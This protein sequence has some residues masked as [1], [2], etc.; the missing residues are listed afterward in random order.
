MYHNIQYQAR[1]SG[2]IRYFKSQMNQNYY[3]YLCALSQCVCS[4]LHNHQHLSW[5]KSITRR[6]LDE[7]LWD[8]CSLVSCSRLIRVRIYVHVHMGRGLKHRIA[9]VILSNTSGGALAVSWSSCCFGS[10]VHCSICF[11]GPWLLWIFLPPM[12][13]QM[14][15]SWSSEEVGMTWS[16]SVF[17]I[18]S[19][20]IKSIPAACF[21]VT[22]MKRS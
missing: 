21:L 1:K 2:I 7:I 12:P 4:D 6:C 13:M 14:T 17:V 19:L 8:F 9:N 10:G 11:D 3:L 5:E 16:A 20:P 15:R 18:S 22:K